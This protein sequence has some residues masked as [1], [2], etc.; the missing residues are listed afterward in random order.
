MNFMQMFVN[1]KEMPMLMPIYTIVRRALEPE[2]LAKAV[3]ALAF[4][5]EFEIGD[6]CHII[7]KGT[8]TRVGYKILP[9]SAKNS[10]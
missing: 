5:R 7:L 3:H 1:L 9:Y 6:L 10:F 8:D 2:D 4:S